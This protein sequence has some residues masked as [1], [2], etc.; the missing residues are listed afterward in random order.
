MNSFYKTQINMPYPWVVFLVENP[1]QYSPVLSEF[2]IY[3]LY[4]THTLHIR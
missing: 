4:D 3:T 2:S 1:V